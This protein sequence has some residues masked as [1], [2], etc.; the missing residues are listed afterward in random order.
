MPRSMPA[1]PGR[2]PGQCRHAISSTVFSDFG[3]IY[4]MS[5][6]Y[7]KQVIPILLPGRAGIADIPGTARVGT[8]RRSPPAVMLEAT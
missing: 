1:V 6:R 4:N 2:R 8:V 5:L 3:A 7:V